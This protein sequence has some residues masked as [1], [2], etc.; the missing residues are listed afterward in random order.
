MRRVGAF[1]KTKFGL[2][3]WYD[4]DDK[5]RKFESVLFNSER[6]A[7]ILNWLIQPLA[8]T[9][10]LQWGGSQIHTFTTIQRKVQFKHWF[11]QGN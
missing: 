8:D 1:R 4:N 2:N 6:K 5:I 3:F 9:N 7:K 10:R 11:Y